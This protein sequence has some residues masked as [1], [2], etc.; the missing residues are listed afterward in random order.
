MLQ[1][2]DLVCGNQKVF[3]TNP[4]RLSLDLRTWLSLG[5]KIQEEPKRK[6]PSPKVMNF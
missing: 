5:L 1:D 2:A 3:K 4:L 6:N